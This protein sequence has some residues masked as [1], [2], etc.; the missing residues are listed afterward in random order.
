M[1]K[2]I[3]FC[4]HISTCTFELQTLPLSP[5]FGTKLCCNCNWPNGTEP[6]RLNATQRD[7]TRLDHPSKPMTKTKLSCETIENKFHLLQVERTR[8]PHLPLY[9]GM[10]FLI[11]S[12]TFPPSF[13]FFC[14]FFFCEGCC[15]AS[16]SQ[17]TS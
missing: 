16:Y 13:F 2:S 12:T 6:S 7:S 17:L 15:V 1:S 11:P 4:Q 14:Y 10:Q 9:F 3:A 5:P 8:R